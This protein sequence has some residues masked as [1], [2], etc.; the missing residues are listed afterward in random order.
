MI[1]SVNESLETN[2]IDYVEGTVESTTAE[3]VLADNSP[4]IDELSQEPLGKWNRLISRTNWEK[5]ELIHGWR[6]R[7]MEA[8]FSNTVYSDDA[9]SRRVGHLSPQHV[10]RLRRVFERFG[11]SRDLYSGL[12]WS[13]FQAALDWEDAEMWLEGAVQNQWSVAS[14]RIRRWE[15]LGGPVDMKPKDQDIV[16]SELDEDVNPHNDS[17]SIIEGTASRIEPADK[18]KTK[19]EKSSDAYDFGA[20]APFDTD[21]A[22]KKKKSKKDPFGLDD[23]DIDNIP[24]T[25]EVLTQL[26]EVRELPSDLCDAFEQLKVAILNHK[27]SMWRDVDPQRIL[28]FLAAMRV[29]VLSKED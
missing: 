8:G 23:D 16:A 15:T 22:P 10:G 28:T 17:A 7:L 12:F 20:D 3:S 11:Q 25:R 27:V 2:E 18:S 26:K 24:S 5:G 1:E 4:L 19:T 21:D 14:M 13:H 6:T 29:M 9:W